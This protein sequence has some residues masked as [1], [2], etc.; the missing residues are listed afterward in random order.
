MVFFSDHTGDY[1][2]GSYIRNPPGFSHAPFS[3]KGCTLFVKPH[4]FLADD[5]HRACINYKEKANDGLWENDDKFQSLRLHQW[6]PE[7]VQLIRS[8]SEPTRIYAKARTRFK[9]ALLIGKSES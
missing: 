5:I 7:S 2:A 1:A 3:L 6:E 8:L 9:V 4:Q